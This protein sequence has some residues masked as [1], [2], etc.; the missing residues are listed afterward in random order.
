MGRHSRKG[1]AP[2]PADTGRPTSAEQR[3]T[4]PEPGAAGPGAGTGRRRRTTAGDGQDPTGTPSGGTPRYGAPPQGG[5]PPYGTP[6]HG[7]PAYG[8]QG[9]G[10]PAHGTPM[11][12][13]PAHGT[14]A[15]GAPGTPAHGIPVH[16]TGAVRGGHPQHDEGGARPAPYDGR[17]GRTLTAEPEQGDEQGTFVPAPRHDDDDPDAEAPAARGGLGRTLAGVG[18]AAVATVLAVVVTGQVTGEEAPEA[19]PR[20]AGEPAER[21]VDDSSASRSEGRTTPSLPTAPPE[22]PAP[23]YEQLMNRQFPI[24]PKLKGSGA[25]EAVQG[26][27]KAPGKGKLIRYRVDVEKGLGLDPKLFADAVQKT[28]NDPRSWAGNGAMTFERISGGEAQFVITLASPGTTGVWCRKSGL[29]TTVDNVSCDSASTERV[30]INAF[31]WA[32]GADTF[33]PKAIHAYRQMLI[34]HEIG[35]RLGHNHVNCRTPGAL[36]PVMQQ[37]TKSLDIDGV[38][39]RPN[40]WVHPGS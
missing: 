34:N 6:A 21:A 20:A 5:A 12:G 25:F 18:A 13:T 26:F 11:Y 3:R 4:A 28:L 29:D 30:M 9:Y 8:G 39:C 27:Q 37:Q 36:A 38:R 2:S 33:G 17:R 7:V 1:S 14:P 15:Y 32:Q 22:P 16:R 40:P 31:R 24:D 23:T 10:T 19:A 35:H